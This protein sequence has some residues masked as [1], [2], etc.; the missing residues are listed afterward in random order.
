VKGCYRQ[1]RDIRV[2]ERIERAAKN[3]AIVPVFVARRAW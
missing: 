2:D 1:A 3:D